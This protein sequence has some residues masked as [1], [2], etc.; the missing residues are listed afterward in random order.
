MSTSLPILEVQHLRKVYKS[1]VAVND[2]SLQVIEG[3]CLGLLGPNGAGKTT[4]IEIIEDIIP[5]TSGEI[6]YRGKPRAQSFREEVGI[7]FQHTSLLNYLSVLETLKTF[8]K[9]FT[10]PEELDFLIEKCQLQ[11]ILERRNNKL[12]GGQQQRLLLALALINKPNLVFLD[13]PST[14]LDPQARRNLW[15]IV[16]EIKAEGKTII[17]TTHSMEEA[18]HLCDRVAIMDQGDIIADG[19]PAELIE[20]YCGQGTIFLPGNFDTRI[21]TS[22]PYRWLKEHNRIRIEGDDIH[23]IIG[24]L[25]G[26][27][28]DLTGMSIGA[29]NLE[30]VFIR[31]TGRQ[32]RD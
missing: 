17:L 30:D 13:E 23:A 24:R 31:L 32:L 4:T 14:G 6:R 27:N 12:S 16:E 11:P 22:L 15:G 20:R 2:V 25:S 3:T 10:D 9:L 19:S 21:L 5:P 18:E 8:A 29:A 28:A 26:M 1:T 7:Q